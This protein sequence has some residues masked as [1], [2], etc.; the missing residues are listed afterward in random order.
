MCFLLF[1]CNLIF[2]LDLF[3]LYGF[4]FMHKKVMHMKGKR[5]RA[6]VKMSADRKLTQDDLVI[7][8]RLLSLGKHI[9]KMSGC[10]AT[11]L[12]LNSRLPKRR[13]VTSAFN[14]VNQ[15]F[16][17]GLDDLPFEYSFEDN[18]AC[19]LHDLTQFPLDMVHERLDRECGAYIRL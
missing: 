11:P 16:C 1:A 8:L 14:Y 2:M 12:K 5:K 15:R 3:S 7:R 18:K 4:V 9:E 6:V 13:C 19:L 10:I 17:M